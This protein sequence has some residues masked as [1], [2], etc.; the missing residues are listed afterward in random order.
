MGWIGVDLFFVLSG[1][2]ITRILLNSYQHHDYFRNFYARRVQRIFPLYYSVLA[3]VFVGWHLMPAFYFE[4]PTALAAITP[5]I[6]MQNWLTSD[7]HI[8][9]L[10]VFWTLA[11][12]EQF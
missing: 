2:L 1:F 7:G 5:W 3:L 10:G 11:I 6:H 12:E 4:P 9:A 8:P